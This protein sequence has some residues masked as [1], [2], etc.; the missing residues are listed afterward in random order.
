M[1]SGHRIEKRTSKWIRFSDEL[2]EA[3]YAAYTA[4]QAQ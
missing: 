3:K 2:S 1:A 4:A